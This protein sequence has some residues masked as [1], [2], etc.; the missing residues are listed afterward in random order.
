ME[1]LKKIKKI[2]IIKISLGLILAIIIFSIFVHQKV[3]LNNNNNSEIKRKN[4]SQ[5]DAI[6]SILI[7]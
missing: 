6:D 1:E 5:Q 3:E 4:N 2:E 7:K